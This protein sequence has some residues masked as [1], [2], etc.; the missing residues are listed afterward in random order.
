MIHQLTL[1]FTEKQMN[2]LWHSSMKSFWPKYKDR[3]EHCGANAHDP[4]NHFENDFWFM[5]KD[6]DHEKLNMFWLDT[7]ADV[8]L[9]CAM[10]DQLNCKWAHLWDLDGNDCI[11][12]HCVLTDYQPR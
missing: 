10:L 11:G 4:D 5:H 3:F 8:F 2:R 12:T 9:F 1:N 7:N 6:V